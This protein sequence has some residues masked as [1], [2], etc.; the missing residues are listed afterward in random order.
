MAQTGYDF[1]NTFTDQEG[2]VWDMACGKCPRCKA[3]SKLSHW[4]SGG[5]GAGFSCPECS[6]F[7]D[8]PLWEPAES[9][10]ITCISD[11][12]A[13]DDPDPEV[14]RRY[15]EYHD[16]P[17]EPPAD[18]RLEGRTT[19]AVCHRAYTWGCG[20][21]PEQESAHLDHQDTTDHLLGDCECFVRRP[22][23]MPFHS[24]DE[25]R[26]RVALVVKAIRDEDGD[27]V[28]ALARKLGW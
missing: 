21:T 2:V 24:R 10:F 20:H 1:T 9:A 22:G 4:V 19:C 25:W 6:V 15:R 7:Y 16:L 12:E 8:E 23:Y 18:P 14:R 17:P 28:D 13:R 3:P 5:G 27:E 11:D 26:E